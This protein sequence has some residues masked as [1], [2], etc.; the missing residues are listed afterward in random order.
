MLGRKQEELA[1]R[2]APPKT[3]STGLGAHGLTALLDTQ[4]AHPLQ[5]QQLQNGQ[6]PL[7]EKELSVLEKLKDQ[8][9]NSAAG[10]WWM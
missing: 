7:S 6:M 10:I 9:L 3:S 8:S 1:D 2:Y 4:P 5:Q